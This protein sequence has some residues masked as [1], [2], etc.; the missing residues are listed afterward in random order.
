MMSEF[1]KAVRVVNSSPIQ[2]ADMDDLE[3]ILALQKL[4]YQS[5][6]ELNND[7]SIP[8]LTQ[9]LDE[10]RAEFGQSLFLKLAQDD[11]IIGSVRTYEKAGTCH[12]GRLIVHPAYQNL[13]IGSR[14]MHAIENNFNCRRFELFTS[15]RSERNLYL[16]LKLGYR[17]FKRVSLNEKV[18]LIFLEKLNG[19]YTS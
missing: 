2:K 3:E 18:T 11:R 10:I 8:P 16:Y 15:Q 6:A 5:E 17:E 4:A 1:V 12:I 13:G 14:L 19:S 9:T 7:F